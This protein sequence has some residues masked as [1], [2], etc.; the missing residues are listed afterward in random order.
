MKKLLLFAAALFIAGSTMAQDVAANADGVSEDGK[1][2]KYRRS[3][4]YT[5][6]IKHSDQAQGETINNVF[7]SLPT[8]DKFNNHDLQI[9]SFESSAVKAKKKASKD[10]DAI[11]LADIQ[12]FIAENDIARQMIAKWFNRD[13][14]GNMNI[15]LL[16]E[17]GLYSAQQSDI[18]EAQNSSYGIMSLGDQGEELIGKTFLLVNDITYAD[19][20]EKSAK[21]AGAIRFLGALAGAVTGT[22]ISNLTDMA[23][24][25]VNEIDGFGVNITSYLFRLDWNKD[26]LDTIYAEHWLDESITDE[27]TRNARLEAFKLSDLFKL[28]YIGSTSTTKGFTA[29]KSFTKKTED[30][31][32]QVACGRALDESILNLQRSYDEFKVSVPILSINQDAKT[33]EVA[34]GLKEGI[35]EKSK[36][37]VLMQVQNEDGTISYNKIGSIEPVAGQIWDNRYG[38]LEIAEAYAADG[39]K[40]KG[41]DAKG[42]AYLKATTFNITAGADRIYPGCLVREVKI[43]NTS[44]RK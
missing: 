19:K 28:T 42:N 1:I 12:A 9:K 14:N 21:A 24:A 38:A 41:E 32:M 18:E 13:E 3:S 29:S 5:V 20:G 4:L 39:E 2:Q 44:K 34:I 22:D 16:S 40:P 8:P 37:E 35:N 43:E 15:D 36:F 33:C 6:L 30:E 23:A 10:R 26:I 27:A 11:N 7:M 31:Q 25:G 17:R